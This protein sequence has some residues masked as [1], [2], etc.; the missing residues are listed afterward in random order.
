MPT[1]IAAVVRLKSETAEQAYADLITV[2]L[3]S[4]LG[5]VLTALTLDLGFGAALAAVLAVSG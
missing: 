5:L 3:W 1:D 4:A 2:S